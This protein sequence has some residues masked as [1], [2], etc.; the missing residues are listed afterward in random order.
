MCGCPVG[1]IPVNV[2]CFNSLPPSFMDLILFYLGLTQN[3]EIPPIITQEVQLGNR[4]YQG[5]AVRRPH[6]PGGCASPI[7]LTRLGLCIQP[8]L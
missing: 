7:I 4:T 2:I 3:Y 5:S 8:N 1:L 6:L